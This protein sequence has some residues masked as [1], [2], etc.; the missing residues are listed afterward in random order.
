M[1]AFYRY[2]D[3]VVTIRYWL[4][5]LPIVQWLVKD[6]TPVSTCALRSELIEHLDPLEVWKRDK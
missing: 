6:R 4:A 2:G 5:G 1:P 3:R